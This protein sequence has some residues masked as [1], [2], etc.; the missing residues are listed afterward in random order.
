MAQWRAAV[1][2]GLQEILYLKKTGTIVAEASAHATAAR[3]KLLATTG[4]HT[5]TRVHTMCLS[6]GQCEGRD[7][8]VFLQTL[9]LLL[10]DVCCV[11]DH[12]AAAPARAPCTA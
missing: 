11:C 7:R 6:C 3:R 1:G 5:Y 8:D 12:Q 9:Y 2:K 10:A 4:G